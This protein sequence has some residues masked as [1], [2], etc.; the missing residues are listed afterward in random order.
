MLRDL[1]IRNLA[2]LEETAI[3]FG[4]GFNV[5]SGETGAGKSIVVDSLALLSGVRASTDL[6]R[7]GADAL[8]VTGFFEPAGDG[9]WRHL[10]KDAG[11]EAEGDELIIRR[12][13]TRTGRNRV[14]VNDR[15]VTLKLLD[16]LAPSLM[17]LHGQREELGLVAADLQRTWLD[18]CGGRDAEKLL[19]RTA[20]TFHA[21][22][23]LAVRLERLT[24][25][26]RA[27]QERTDLLRFQLSE[28]DVAEI[29]VDE[30][31][32]LRQERDVLQHSGAIQQALAHSCEILFDQESS[33]YDALA[34]SLQVL[35]QV[36]AWEPQAAEW[37]AELEELRIR[38]GELHEALSRR[39]EEVEADPRRL[40]VVEDRLAILERLFRKH[41]PSTREVLAQRNAI[42][43]E[44]G[45]LEGDESARAEL[46]AQVGEALDAF[47]AAATELS[48]GR[49]R[50]AELLGKR[51]L[52]DL[53][54]LA[55]DKARF[56]VWLE[57]RKR[58]SSPLVI[59]AEPVEFSE[60]GFDQVVFAFSPNPGEELRPLA[61]AASGGELSRLYLAVQLAARA[62]GRT[63]SSTA[64]VFDE[65]DV[66]IGGA[67]AAAL[68]GK[69][70]RLAQGGQILAVTHLPQVA[71]YADRHFKVH[72]QVRKG[73]TYTEV[74][75]LSGELRAEEVARM[76]AGSEI[77]ELSLS[78]AREL[79]G[80]GAGN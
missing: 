35:Q 26:D 20:E 30:E 13:I 36:E 68:G 66:G 21:Y 37:G 69:L 17:R 33:A 14:F 62:E 52:R 42:A 64:L 41:G 60:L 49:R 19:R 65:V 74:D 7:T 18:R 44:L 1:H 16:E 71:S 34:R 67:Q 5:L 79:I 57:R 59:A 11:L 2:V 78:H 6:I 25:D 50:W 23:T 3:E 9:G 72:K 47:K 29:K 12:E 56:T 80:A 48:Q 38:I 45:E 4:S 51:V 15:P 76:L 58:S 53:R 32:T 46:D 31:V 27:R 10:L 24:G 54:E 61:K 43:A 77:T 70:R 40:D 8:T 73:R 63:A 28:I 39:R 22:R 75:L 55:F